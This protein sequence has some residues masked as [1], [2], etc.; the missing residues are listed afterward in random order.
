M[1][2]ALETQIQNIMLIAVLLPWQQ[3]QMF[4]YPQVKNRFFQP[5]PAKLQKPSYLSN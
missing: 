2:I 5:A 4:P 3:R 1:L